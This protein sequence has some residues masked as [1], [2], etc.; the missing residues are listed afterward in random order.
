MA[1]RAVL[2][3]ALVAALGGVPAARAQDPAV[4]DTLAPL[5][6]DSLLEFP[7][8]PAGA[9]AAPTEA[10]GGPWLIEPLG[11]KGFT[12]QHYNRVDG[13]TPAWGLALQPVDPARTPAI[14]ARLAAATSHERLYWHLWIEQRLPL[15]GA[16]LA[17]AE[18]FHR[19]TTF[20]DWKVSVREN[21]ASTFLA[22]SDLLDWWRER[23]YRLSL[24]AETGGGTLG[25]RV[26]VFGA[27]QH[28][29]PN[30]SPFALFSEE[31]YRAN[32]P[33][34]EGTLR[35]VSLQVRV[36]TRDVQSPLLPAPGW[37]AT[38]E[39]E[40]SGGWLGG[41][42][43]FSRVTADV[44]RYTRLGGDAWWDTRL[45]WMGALD[46][47][48]VPPQRRVNLGGPGSLRGFPASSFTGPEG[49]QGSTEVR[50]PLPLPDR[51]ALLLLS[52]HAVG[53]ADVGSVGAYETW[54]ADVGAGLSGLNIFTYIG[55][56]V[57]QRV[58][59]RDEPASGPRIV[60]RLRRD[61]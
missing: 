54:H 42:L 58:T 56:F 37:S 53:F 26:S 21:D 30:R 61:F 57:A 38:G 59:D 2:V 52:W 36:D 35:S 14:G 8:I 29:E 24:D 4:P 18:H 34:A 32:P 31:N 60:V 1:E 51:L 15:P 41:A 25:G 48:G 45:V 23:G 22:A 44:R 43:D 5:P 46:G 12:L 10:S 40:R 19:T 6:S 28:S 39:W 9:I 7:A 16:V 17:R 50:V 47:D 33:V 20:D 13:L 27:A 49:I 3:L 55:V 11:W